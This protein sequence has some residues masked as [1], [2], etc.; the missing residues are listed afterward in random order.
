ML[1]VLPFPKTV[2]MCRCALE[3]RLFFQIFQCTEKSRAL[4]GQCHVDFLERDDRHGCM[5]HTCFAADVY[6]VSKNVFMCT[7]HVFEFSKY[8]E[9]PGHYP[10][11][12]IMIFV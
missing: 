11:N 5:F 10:D 8:T 3:V 6:L 2:F 7:S 4:P 1:P 12:V 9:N